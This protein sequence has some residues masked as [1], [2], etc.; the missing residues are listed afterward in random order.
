MNLTTQ[1]REIAR[2]LLATKDKNIVN[3]FKA[4]LDTR[5]DDWWDSVPDEIKK[6]IE[7]GLIESEARKLIPHAK[8]MK[9]F[10]KWLKK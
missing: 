6:S 9:R 5:S 7:K 10:K 8:V 1:K 2:R 4:V 3:H